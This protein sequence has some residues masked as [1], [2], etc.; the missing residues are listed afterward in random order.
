MQG[1]FP[2]EVGRPSGNGARP[3]DSRFQ[4]AAGWTLVASIQVRQEWLVIRRGP[5][6]CLI[7][8]LPAIV[9]V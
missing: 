9:S 2:R 3:T 7:Y 4:P 6:G 1:R 8:L 5:D